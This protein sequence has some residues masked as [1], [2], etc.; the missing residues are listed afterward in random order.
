MSVGCLMLQCLKY[1][2]DMKQQ[3]AAKKCL[4]IDLFVHFENP[5]RII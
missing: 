3:W 1:D 5:F 4:A 2:I